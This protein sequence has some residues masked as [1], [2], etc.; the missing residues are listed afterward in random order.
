MSTTEVTV[1]EYQGQE[2]PAAGT[3]AID[4]A[5]STVEFV[6]R[7]LMISKVRGRFTD[8]AGE[9]RI[10]DVPEESSVEVTIGTASVDTGEAGRD[11]HLRGPDF[12]DVAGYPT[13][14]FRSTGVALAKGG[15]WTV[16]GEL[17]IRGVTRPVTLDVEFEGSSPS[18]WGDQRI[19]FTASAEVDR[20]DWGLTWNQALETGGVLVGKKVRIELGVQGI[21]A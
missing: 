10:A 3:Y 13:I 15:H 2:I 18:P 17:T 12:F 19:G 1:R 21:R 5:H 4:T 11:E 9:I 6:A 20:E 7:H 14:T 16:D 8:V